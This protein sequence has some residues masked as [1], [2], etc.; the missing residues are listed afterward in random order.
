[1]RENNTFSGQRVGPTNPF[2]EFKKEEIEQSIPDR[3]EQ[4]VSRYADRLA[5]K[6]KNHTFTYDQLNKTSNRVVHAILD[7]HGKGGTYR[8][9]LRWL[10]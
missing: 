1:M 10:V 2:V 3:F 8:T 7:Q 9:E 5:V 4:M 6:T